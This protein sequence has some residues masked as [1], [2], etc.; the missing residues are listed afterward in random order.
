MAE[1]SVYVIGQIDGL[2]KIGTAHNVPNR[3][4][5]IQCAAPF[6]VSVLLT[7][8]MRDDQHAFALEQMCHNDL[9]DHW[10]YGEWFNCPLD[11]IM[12][13]IEINV[14]KLRDFCIDSGELSPSLDSLW[15]QVGNSLGISRRE[16]IR[17]RTRAGL[18][19]ARARGRVGGRQSLCTDEEI[20]ATK[21]MRPTEAQKRLGFKNL[22]SYI[23]RLA[24]AEANA[25]EAAKKEKTDADLG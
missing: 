10:V 19:A 12:V 22:A 24:V 25:A 6:A 14:A 18:A 15:I 21:R 3:R 9:Q 2:K 17:E 20:L 23:R 4:N 5:Y 11:A 13:S 7:E 1:C 16:V 8:V